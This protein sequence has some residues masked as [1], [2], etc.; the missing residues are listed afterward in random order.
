MKNEIDRNAP[1][2]A[3]EGLAACASILWIVFFAVALGILTGCATK[4]R[5]VEIDGM[6]VQAESAT[7]ALGSVDVMAA[8]VGEESAIIKYGEDSAW[9]HPETKT[10]SIRIQLTGTNCVEK[11]DKIIE[12]ICRAFIPTA[13]IVNGVTNAPSVRL[14]SE[15]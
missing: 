2:T 1:I 8:P 5:N 3:F 7:L 13:A 6:F 14:K 15:I 9:L 12:H 10:H 4:T 11:V